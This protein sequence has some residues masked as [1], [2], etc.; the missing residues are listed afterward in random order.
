VA[1][2]P[3]PDLGLSDAPVRHAPDQNLLDEIAATVRSLRRDFVTV[4]VDGVDGAGKTTFADRLAPHLASRGLDVVRVSGDDHL[5]PSAVRWRRGR[6][7]PVGFYRDSSDPT[8]L[9]SSVLTPF[10]SSGRFVRRTHDL[11]R[12]AP[13]EPLWEEATPPAALI[14]DGLFLH[15][16]ELADHWDCSVFLDV[17]FEVSVGRM[18]A[19]DGSH[20]DPDHPSQR[21]YVAGQRLYFE[22]CSPWTRATWVVDNTDGLPG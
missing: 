18:A 8:A 13:L 16:D 1:R 4:G 12:D 15:R 21:R 5:N 11:A 22:E 9:A 2:H 14:L 10:R 17:P 3:D 19:R 20:P 7:S 6:D